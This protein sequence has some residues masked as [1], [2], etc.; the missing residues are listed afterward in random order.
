MGSIHK[1]ILNNY[2][3]SKHILSIFALYTVLPFKI[4]A[5]GRKKEEPKKIATSE[6]ESQNKNAYLL[7]VFNNGY[8]L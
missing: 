3:L 8:Y 2:V 5:L 4:F 1:V 7:E 6:S